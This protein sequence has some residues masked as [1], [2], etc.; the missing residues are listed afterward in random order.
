MKRSGH[1]WAIY[2]QKRSEA[3]NPG[4]LVLPMGLGEPYNFLNKHPLSV[5]AAPPPPATALS[6]VGRQRQLCPLAASDVPTAALH[7]GDPQGHQLCRKMSESFVSQ[8]ETP[9]AQGWIALG[10]CSC[11]ETI[12]GK[13]KWLF[14]SNC[15][16]IADYGCLCALQNDRFSSFLFTKNDDTRTLLE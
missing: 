15:V 12:V 10:S 13:G 9:R 6:T 3:K 16:L 11:Q 2:G 7:C 14:L 8:P 1:R 4:R 5:S